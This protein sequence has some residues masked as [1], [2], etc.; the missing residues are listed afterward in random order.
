MTRSELRETDSGA[1]KRLNEVCNLD[2]LHDTFIRNVS[3]EFRTPLA[4]LMGYAEMLYTGELGSLS[5]EQQRAVGIIV[6]RSHELKR[7]VTRINTLLA[8][9]AHKYVRQLLVPT[10]FV[11][12]VIEV[13]RVHAEAAGIALELH[14]STELPCIIGDG[15]QLQ[16][17]FE[18]LLENAIKFTPRGGCITVHLWSDS[19]WVYLSVEDTG[20][21]M[22]QEDMMRLC[23]PF[24]QL[25][26]L[27]SRAYGGLGLGL[28][29]ARS[30]V[31]AHEGEITAESQRGQGS[32]FTVKLP[33]HAAAERSLHT[34]PRSEIM[35][36]ILIVDDEESVAFTLREGLR[37]L[38]CCEIMVALSGHQALEL[39]AQQPFD[40]L[41]TD[42]KMPDLSGM[43]LASC[44]QQRYPGTNIILIT[45]Y[46]R[47]LVQ[48]MVTGHAIRRVLHKPIRLTE[49]RDVAL[50]TLALQA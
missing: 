23:V 14:L 30:I 4:V 7:A 42:Y 19:H 11:T 35:R 18:C 17:A 3:H 32:C 22:A 15:E 47:D 39:F 6:N 28:T 20:I 8:V 50:E 43:A 27:P 12:P 37:K 25:D 48:D 2:A 13:Q 5:P 24:A 1:R 9:Q 29:L 31:V 38:P 16:L 45:A 49:I 44:I 41:I 36:R 26:D 21:G 46:G 40:L 33:L 34:N 10:S